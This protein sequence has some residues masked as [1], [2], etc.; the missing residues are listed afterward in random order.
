MRKMAE[1][2][3]SSRQ[4]MREAELPV[5]MRALRLTGSG[6]LF[7]ARYPRPAASAG[8]AVV[9]VTLAGV[10]ATDLALVDGYKG[11]YRGVL[12]HEFVGQVV[13]APG[14]PEWLGQRVAGELNIGCG[15]CSLCRRG[16]GKHCR[17]RESLG[18]VGRDGAFADYLRLPLANLHRV[19]DEVSDEQAV[20]VE[21]VA[22]ALEILEQLHVAPSSKVVVLGAGRLGLLIAQVMALTGCEL[23]LVGRNPDKLAIARGWGI[24]GIEAGQAHVTLGADAADIV[25][26]A[27]G[28]PSGFALGRELVRPGGTLVL[29]STYAGESPPIDLSHIVVDEIRILGSRCGPFAPA[30]QLLASGRIRVHELISAEFPLVEAVAALRRA[31]QPG[32]LKVLI[33]P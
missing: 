17:Q 13:E 10:C 32:V 12:G 4:Q 8:D 25:I 22:A 5:T 9:E 18:I 2:A 14:Q 16:L 1:Y 11:G 28:A 20:F 29:K 21:P 3:E 31:S 19:P 15:E 30:I 23:T 33:R 6:L 27:T 26:E 7:D 24:E